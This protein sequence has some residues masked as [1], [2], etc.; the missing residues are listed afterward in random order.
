MV[1]T[2]LNNPRKTFNVG[3]TNLLCEPLL[4]GRRELGSD[5]GDL[6]LDAMI[7]EG[8]TLDQGGLSET[9]QPR[10]FR[11]YSGYCFSV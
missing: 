5:H 1:L 9:V 10:Q 2:G 4:P 11:G 6:C 3:C 7:Q 8:P